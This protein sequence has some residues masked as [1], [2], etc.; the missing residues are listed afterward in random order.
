M[1]TVTRMSEDLPTDLM[2]QLD[3]QKITPFPM[4]VPCL[5][6]LE[7]A[8]MISVRFLTMLET[9]FVPTSHQ[10]NHAAVHFWREKLRS[11][12][13][14]SRLMTWVMF[15]VLLWK[16]PMRLLLTFMVLATQIEQLDV[17]HF[18]SH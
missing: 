4:T 13:L 11:R 15:L 16:G 17:L 9:L 18:P 12:V 3:L 6:G 14:S 7:V 1:N 5:D 8:S 10:P 2:V